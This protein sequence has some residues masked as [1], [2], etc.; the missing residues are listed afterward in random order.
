M[1]DSTVPSGDLMPGS[2]S[3][4][5]ALHVRSRHEKTVQAQLD[6]KQFE[7]FL[8]LYSHKHK[9]ADRWKAVSLPFFPGYVFCHF[10]LENRA[11]AITT[12]GVIDIVRVGDDPAPIP[13]S[14][15][16][17]IRRIVNSPLLAE[18]CSNL[19]PGQEVT[20]CG[21]PL[22]GLS[23]TLIENCKG[24]RLVIS[25]SLLHRA[26]LVEIDREWVI[27]IAPLKTAMRATAE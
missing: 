7:V 25:I 15:I 11:S 16:E 8:P 19:V 6:A 21:G 27:A 22:Q 18:P 24:L 26:V 17:S 4:W 3:N 1:S 5:Y 14:D 20:M 10:E 13:D 2:R 12:S 9:W 23:G